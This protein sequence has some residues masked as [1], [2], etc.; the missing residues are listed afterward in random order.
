V[1]GEELID[2]FLDA[3]WA[4]RGLSAN[5]LESYRRDLGK[6][7][8][9]LRASG[10]PL[11]QASREDLL[12][13]FARE[14]R[15][16]RSPRSISRYLSGFRQFY[17]WLVREGRLTEDP[18]ALIE[19]PKVGRGLPKALSEAEVEALLNRPDTE[20]PLGL[21]DRAMLELMY[22]TGLRVSELT[23]LQLTNLY[24]NQGT[25]RVLGK[26][27][28]E[29]LVPIGEQALEWLQQY[30]RDAR[31]ELLNGGRS[32]A[33]FVTARKGPM[34]RQ[35]FWYAVGRHARAAGIRQ[36]IS[37]HGLRHSFAT[38]LLNHG[39]D[40]RVVQLLLGHSDLSTTQIYTHVAREGLKRLHE[41]HHPRG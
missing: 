36:K 13:F 34:T 1:S 21:R 32:S 24:L 31:P 4:E 29:R 38:H 23:G 7:S 41:K 20:T 35:A 18:T 39:A 25:L 40:L 14:M 5:T 33:V 9:A 11:E 3:A 12:G 2:H 22:A 6:L 30:L 27:G 15:S 10:K 16:G 19:S 17:R 28:K 8:G 26:G 37:P